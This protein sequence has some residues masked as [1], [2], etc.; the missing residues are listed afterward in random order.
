[1]ELLLRI[2]IRALSNSILTSNKFI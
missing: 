2:T 1:M